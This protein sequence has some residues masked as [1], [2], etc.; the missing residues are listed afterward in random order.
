MESVGNPEILME[1]R[2]ILWKSKNPVGIHE[3]RWKSK[4]SNGNPLISMEIH[5]EFYFPVT[6]LSPEN[7]GIHLCWRE[8]GVGW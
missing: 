4:K 1:I 3:I 2:K 6:P 5:A 7:T 8:R